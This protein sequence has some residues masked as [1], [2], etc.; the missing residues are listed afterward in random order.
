MGLVSHYARG[1]KSGE[2]KKRWQMTV[3]CL[4][5]DERVSGRELSELN[6]IEEEIK[7]ERKKERER[8][9]ER[10]K[11]LSSEN[12]AHMIILNG[13]CVCECVCV[14]VLMNAGFIIK[15]TWD[16]SMT[17]SHSKH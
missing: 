4:W 13:D 10:R 16:E 8:E 12:E 6:T 7:K 9:R 3:E 11:F 5:A 14:C 1:K 2:W 17:R 15:Y